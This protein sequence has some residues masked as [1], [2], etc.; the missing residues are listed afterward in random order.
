MT[1]IESKNENEKEKEII[2]LPEILQKET[3][4]EPKKESHEESH[5]A[6]SY[7]RSLIKNILDSSELSNVMELK[8]GKYKNST[9]KVFP[10][11]KDKN[12]IAKLEEGY[13][14]SDSG[15]S[16]QSA[17]TF[18]SAS[19][20]TSSNI[21][22]LTYLS[23]FPSSDLTLSL[24][25]ES[26]IASKTS[27]LRIFNDIHMLKTVIPTNK[28]ANNKN[29]DNNDNNKGKKNF[30]ES[31][32]PLE[33][34]EIFPNLPKYKIGNE[35]NNEFI[36]PPIL[37]IKNLILKNYKEALFFT[38]NRLFLQNFKNTPD[39][40]YKIMNKSEVEN[41]KL[42]NDD[43]T[44]MIM[45]IYQNYNTDTKN[46]NIQQINQKIRNISSKSMNFIF[47]GYKNGL[48]RQYI[49][50]YTNK[51][52][53]KESDCEILQPYYREYSIDYKIK[54][55]RIDRHVLCMSLSD[56]E[57]ILL[58]GYASGHIILWRTTDGKNLYY[59]DNIFDMPVVACELLFVSDNMK[60]FHFL[61]S[62][63]VGKVN[64]IQLQKNTF[65]K[66]DVNKIIV[67]NCFY[68][69]LLIK[70]LKFNNTDDGGKDFDIKQIINKINKSPY[71]CILANLEYIEVLS[72][73]K[74]L[75]DI[76][77]VL[78]IK[79]PDFNILNPMTDEI[80]TNRAE[81]YS[82][83]MLRENLSKIEFPDACFGLGYLNDVNKYYTSI[84]SDNSPEI[85]FA[86]SWKN[87]IKLYLFS[88]R[89]DEIGWY[90]NN[91]P[92]IKIGFIGVS[93]LYL[94]DKNNNIKIINTKLFNNYLN[95]VT[96]SDDNDDN[97]R[98]KNK[99]IIPISDIISL[100]YPVK[101]I[102]K[103]FTETINYYAPFIINN[104]SNI[105]LITDLG[106]KNKKESNNI[107]HIHLLSYTEFF[108][109]M[110]KEEKWEIFF[111]KFIDIIKTGTNTFGLIPENQDIKENLLIEK[112]PLKKVKFDYLKNY[113]EYNKN[114][115]DEDEDELI[116]LEDYEYLSKAIEFAIEIG[117]IDFIYNEIGASNKEMIKKQ[118]V[119][120]LGPFIL[121]N[122]F[123]KNPNL[124]SAELINDMVNYYLKGKSDT[125]YVEERNVRLFTL[126]L[127]LCHLHMDIVK[128]IKNIENIIE[129]YK[130]T[131]SIIYYYS[132]GLNNF[133]K[134]LVYLFNE[135]IS[136]EPVLPSK[137]KNNTN[138]FKRLKGSRGYYRDN[139]S[140]LL[141]SLKSGHGGFDLENNLFK[142]K[143]FMGH[144]LLFYI[145][146]T[147][148][149]FMFPNLEKINI[150][151]F[152]NVV[153]EMFLFLTQRK[154]AEELIKF[155]CYS[156]FETLAFFFFKE[157]EINAILNDEMIDNFNEKKMNENSCLLL[158]NKIDEN[159][160]KKSI[161][162]YNDINNNKSIKNEKDKEKYTKEDNLKEIEQ[163]AQTEKAQSNSKNLFFELIS[164]IISLCDII[165]ENILIRFDLN[166][167]IIKL[168]L[169]IHDIS[170][171][172]LKA[173]LQSI[174]N[175]YNDIK[176]LKMDVNA[177][178]ILFERIDKFGNHYSLIRR[179]QSILDNISSIINL[180]I[181]IY[182]IK[183]KSN[184][185]EINNLFK[186]CF[187]SHFLRVKIY[188]YE[189][190]KDYMGCI[191]V[192][193]T[194]KKK[195]SRRVFTF[196]NKTLNTLNENK[197]FKMLQT[198]KN[199][200]KKIITNLARVS[201]SETFN[202]I[203]KWFNS[204]DIIS[205][206]NNLPKLQ[207]RYIDKLKSIYKSR[208][209]REKEIS[210]DTLKKEYSNILLIYIKLLF[211]FD[212]GKRVI[213]LFKDEEEYIN[214]NECLKISINKSIEASVYLY[215]LIGDEK[216]ALK[217]CLNQIKQNYKDIKNKEKNN[218]MIENLF[219]E[220]KY[221]I[222]ESIELCEN[223]SENSEFFKKR[224]SSLVLEEKNLENMEENGTNNMGEE[225]WLD[226]FK[227]IY[228]I[229]KDCQN[230]EGFIFS[231]IK[232]YLSEKIENLLVT[233]G[234]Y[235]S[236]NFILKSVSNELE[237]S[238]IKKF[239]NKNIYT[240][241]HLSYLY[242]SYLNLLTFKINKDINILEKNSQK[243]KNI[244]L[245]IKEEDEINK[246]KQV[247][248][249]QLSK[250]N[251]R[252]EYTRRNSFYEKEG[253]IKG[254][255]GIIQIEKIYKKC[256][257]CNQMLNFVNEK[258]DNDNND[259]I[260]FKCNHIFHNNC[261]KKEY[262]NMIL[263]L[264]YD[265]KIS[266]KF[267]PKCININ[268]ELFYFI[269]DDDNEFSAF[270]KKYEEE[271]EKNKNMINDSISSD[272]EKRKKI[273]EEKMKKKNWK[274]L[275]LLDNNYFEKISILENT[276][277]GI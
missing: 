95:N 19:S 25:K 184:K 206:L 235:V 247:L 154:V 55:T 72:I 213:K 264:K 260:I 8:L 134:P 44:C 38:Q 4:I 251:F 221:L 228:N 26:N 14:D 53:E 229:L 245:V 139:Y 218:M 56:K 46:V 146:L 111:C 207:F 126:D 63:L 91:S 208:L 114:N 81:F 82:Q 149:E 58:A 128:K 179:K 119:S 271:N 120:K 77:T 163:E 190:K 62:D 239:L 57:N 227:E 250:H 231:K 269:K 48:I 16:T 248:M 266:Q 161:E 96:P 30:E 181:N 196:I 108:D 49:L 28:K 125:I 230:K 33:Y 256:S 255:K 262:S 263:N 87:E 151:N 214:V 98:K 159:E 29:G 89:L 23:S 90:L 112:K 34:F 142:T 69:C 13:E 106:N 129:D 187:S 109:K 199:E 157:D 165:P 70:K 249:N 164:S 166:V 27:F 242:K 74:Q 158:I 270:N 143:E 232:N 15:D 173:S 102:S 225:Y 160:L 135:F 233:M 138:F 183:N 217:M 115:F 273:M 155:D 257:L 3:P 178:S 188:I 220:I 12:F 219:N 277:D 1:E 185:D 141:R 123:Q 275:N 45:G 116:N 59:F 177:L 21:S 7:S 236:F 162:E 237:F 121:N 168:S 268:T 100:E 201:Q 211:Y 110:M 240:K 93:L 40:Q 244:N 117:S 172:I 216:S 36:E 131:C 99:F 76:T 104:K 258:I 86:Y 180:F 66:D 43:I 193:L 32:Y 254:K 65:M 169:K 136:I 101:T 37:F 94:L 78:L 153:Q 204:I 171:E 152:G 148:K 267:C 105:F 5:K 50:L 238:L 67:S 22:G 68:P 265:I 174:F 61:V 150:N 60:E 147:L 133:I 130:L 203:Q 103:T 132:Y 18:L 88:H 182:Y 6:S 198:Y 272:I 223:Y 176:K 107:H 122:K 243:G 170:P 54:D 83:K 75:N 194:E 127:I 200:I 212:K 84:K 71:I 85:L 197:E 97:K 175:F 11:K 195:I 31:M 79:N 41:N 24:N 113:I 9:R 191:N 80:K 64:L 261:L 224:K 124:I 10:N 137:E 2:N 253:K 186:A 202:I 209:K 140:N 234:Y 192:Y 167:F 20:S 51:K 17:S 39:F 156:Y 92:I 189:L 226:V 47:F 222:D 73:N 215:K 259:I 145:Q 35:G 241:S 276:L 210:N 42:N 274:K 144:L 205:S 52:D 118:L 252:Y 246:E